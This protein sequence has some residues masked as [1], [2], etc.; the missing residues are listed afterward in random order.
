MKG[1]EA[2]TRARVRKVG[3]V[4]GAQA[5]VA[6]FSCLCGLALPLAPEAPQPAAAPFSIRH[7]GSGWWLVSPEGKSFFSLGVCTT[8]QG[9]SR[10]SFDPENPG[11]AAWQHYNSPAAWADATLR[12]LSSWG[13]TTLSAWSDFATLRQSKEQTLWLTPVLHLG[14]PAGAPWWDMW[15]PV[16]L[17]RMEAIAREEILRFRDDPRLLGYYSDNELGWWN[18]TLWKTTLEQAPSSGQRQRLIQLLR[19]T[20]QNDW[21]RLRQ[22]FEPEKAQSWESLQEGGMLYVKPGSGGFKV[23]RRFL[24]LVAERYYQLV[25]DL[26]RKYDQRGLILGDRYQSFYYPEVARASARWV[27]ASSSN[28]SAAW[29]D[30]SYLRCYLETL[31]QLTGKPILVSEFYMAARENRS[32]N[33]N[34]RGVFPVAATQRERA[35]AIRNTLARLAHTPYVLGADWFQY[36]DEPRYGRDDGENFNFG[37]VDI[38]DCP[39]G[40]VTS[41]F[42]NFDGTALKAQPLP[43]MADA[44]AG[45]PRA[46]T[47]PFADFV[48]MRALQQWDRTRG[49]IKSDSAEP[50]ADLY[51]CWSPTAIYLGLFALDVTEDACYRDRSVPKR[52]RALWV[53]QLCG[54]ELLRVRLGAGREPIA[55]DPAVRVENLSGVNLTVRSITAVAFTAKQLGRKRFRPGDKIQLGSTFWTHGQCYRMDWSGTFVLGK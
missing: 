4:F 19:D 49:F 23:M 48:P 10:Q 13:F 35:T 30:G 38:N 47:D 17:E 27:D 5:L 15:D 52:D 44:S 2:Q 45:V 53:V 39:Y 32:G 31:H 24:G 51:I 11:Y 42:A 36:F 7:E 41:T 18:A 46:P 40:E 22:D 33:R 20:Y 12:R 55:N 1:I 16:V 43:P 54:R 14:G 34:N 50:L 3:T 37:L 28:L 21:N 26:I 25:H 6:S 9:I 29:N 8:G